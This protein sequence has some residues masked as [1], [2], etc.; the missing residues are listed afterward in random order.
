MSCQ[1][2]ILPGVTPAEQA[3]KKHE[4]QWSKTKKKSNYSELWLN[5]IATNNYVQ[6][7]A[8]SI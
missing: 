1:E 5:I 3:I 7:H 8:T 4:K 6:K 2:V